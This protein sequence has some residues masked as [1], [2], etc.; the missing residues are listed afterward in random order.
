VGAPIG[1]M[2]LIIYLVRTY[3][4]F[5]N[6]GED[7][8]EDDSA[9]LDDNGRRFGQW[10]KW[11]RLSLFHFGLFV[12]VCVLSLW[13]VPDFVAELTRGAIS[14][15][16]KYKWFFLGVI[17][18]VASL[19]VWV[20]YLKYKISEK[21]MDRQMDLEKF[22]VEKQLLLERETRLALPDATIPLKAKAA[23]G[24][25]GSSEPGDSTQRKLVPDGKSHIGPSSAKA[26]T[27]YTDR[28]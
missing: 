6:G 23:Q 22:R 17:V 13:L 19:L 11:R 18:F 16:A 26:S 10:F 9:S 25:D 15:V 2:L 8:N 24:N 27:G 5:V 7:E 12:L 3:L 14:L 28:R 1:F 20:I 4:S 21:M